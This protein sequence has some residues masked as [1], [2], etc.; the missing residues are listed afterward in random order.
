[1]TKSVHLLIVTLILCLIHESA[2]SKGSAQ[3]GGSTNCKNDTQLEEA[4]TFNYQ[5]ASPN[6]LIFTATGGFD[7]SG[8][9]VP[10][11]WYFSEVNGPAGRTN[12]RFPSGLFTLYDA[13]MTAHLEALNPSRSYVI[14]LE[15]RDR[16]GNIKRYQ[17]TLTTPPAGSDGAPPYVGNLESVDVWVG[18][19]SARYVR[20]MAD[21]DSAVKQVA[22]SI[23]G[24]PL[25]STGV[26]TT[27]TPVES[28][29]TV[30]TPN[31]MTEA[32][33]PYLNGDGSLS[34]IDG[35]QFGFYPDS[36]KYTD[37]CLLK[38]KATVTDIYGKS[39]VSAEIPL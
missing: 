37:Y 9:V 5:Y 25:S 38:V 7:K 36:L 28:V 10:V 16:C 34:L 35:S 12:I 3:N 14:A 4:M 23:T 39:R 29:D 22:F 18:L 30:V 19:G 6:H 20:L 1:M 21:D 13:L 2:F 24:I 33:H 27:T 26:C 32:F 17:Q 15:S 31:Y 8:T 11:K